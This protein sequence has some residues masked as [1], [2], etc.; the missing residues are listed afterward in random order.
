MDQERQNY[1][2]KEERK[3]VKQNYKPLLFNAVLGSEAL[4]P[5]ENWLEGRN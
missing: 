5:P 1:T 3:T 4:A 2:E